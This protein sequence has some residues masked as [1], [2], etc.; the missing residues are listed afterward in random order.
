MKKAICILVLAYY[1]VGS[2]ILPLADFSILPD[3]PQLYAHCKATEDKDLQ[4]TD[5][6]TDHLMNIDGIF[7]QHDNGDEQKPHEPF[8]H[9]TN[10]SFVFL[11]FKLFTQTVLPQEVVKE[12]VISPVKMYHFDFIGNIFRPPIA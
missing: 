12:K 1:S 9:K 8:A 10:I 6:I 4:I 2:L 11:S 3:L 5:F 7:D